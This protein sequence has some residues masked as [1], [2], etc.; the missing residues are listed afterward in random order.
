VTAPAT[1]ALAT[2]P[3]PL[4]VSMAGYVQATASDRFTEP[5][6]PVPPNLRATPMVVLQ[7][8]GTPFIARGVPVMPLYGV[9]A[10][11]TAT[12]VVGPAHVHAVPNP[13]PVWD[14]DA[15][16]G[17]GGW[18][19]PPPA[20]GVGDY[21]WVV[22]V[23]AKDGR[24]GLMN[25][26]D[27]DNGWY[28]LGDPS[29]HDDTADA[30]FRTLQWK[31][32]PAT[33]GPVWHSAYPFKPTVIHREDSNDAGKQFSHPAAV[34]FSASSAQHMWLDM[35]ADVPQPFTWVIVAMATSAADQLHVIL[36]SGV[37]PFSVGF[38]V[39]TP[40]QLADAW[41]VPDNLAYRTTLS[42]AGPGTA[43]M[44]TAVNP[45]GGYGVSYT[46][47]LT[48]NVVPRMYGC[49]YNGSQSMLWVRGADVSQVVHGTVATGPAYKHRYYVLGRAY[50]WVSPVSGCEMFVMEMRFWKKAL[51]AADMEDQYSQLSSTYGFEAYHPQRAPT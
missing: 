2:V 36:D 51:T 6:P 3:I 50:G 37:N 12:A 32:D 31:P 33:G 22:Q 13:D 41:Q 34:S 29:T 35:Q 7:P 39:L 25:P 40:A 18:A 19:M 16:G 10:P 9:I 8:V 42:V 11:V 15:N 5:H 17:L 44:N 28:P 46:K 45:A 43:V 47:P 20:S 4:T 14:P 21:R 27:A 48:F 1:V 24:T 26:V 30:D 38:P 23:G 49:V